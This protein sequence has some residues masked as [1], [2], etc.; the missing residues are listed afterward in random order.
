MRVL[1]VEDN[2]FDAD[3]TRRTLAN[4]APDIDLTV[5]QKLSEAILL[6]DENY[7]QPL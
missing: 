3:L 6:V 2:P 7:F 4:D 5:A 1:Y